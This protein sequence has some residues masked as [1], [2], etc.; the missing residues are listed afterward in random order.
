MYCILL[1][2]LIQPFKICIKHNN[3][4][5]IKQIG[6]INSFYLFNPLKYVLKIYWFNKK[7]STK[8]SVQ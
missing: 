8:I 2:I 5:S 1:F 4:G 3:I 6:S 7:I